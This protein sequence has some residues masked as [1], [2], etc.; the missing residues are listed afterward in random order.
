MA[1]GGPRTEAVLHKYIERLG[2]ATVA[3]LALGLL[4]Y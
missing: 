2:W 3:L 4:L 1:W